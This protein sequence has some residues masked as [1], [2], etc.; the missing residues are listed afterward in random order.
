MKVQGKPYA[1][2]PLSEH[3]MWHKDINGQQADERRG[4]FASNMLC[5]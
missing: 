4:P 1:A 3:F 5:W 2:F